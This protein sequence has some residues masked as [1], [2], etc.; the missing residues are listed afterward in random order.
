MQ[1][2]S[3][4]SMNSMMS[5]DDDFWIMVSAHEKKTEILISKKIK[6]IAI[7]FCESYAQQSMFNCE[8]TSTNWFHDVIML[9]S[10]KQQHRKTL[11]LTCS[12]CV[13]MNTC[14]H[15]FAPAVTPTRERENYD[16]VAFRVSDA[17]VAVVCVG[18]TA[19][20]RM[21]HMSKS[22]CDARVLT[23]ATACQKLAIS[24]DITRSMCVKW[25]E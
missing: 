14:T 11:R 13:A 8:P 23:P 18:I 2:N 12:G 17:C 21:N 9:W 24:R 7:R 6:S 15:T 10:K 20:K 16:T 19:H 5:A 22:H 25:F 4:S 3:L 1:F